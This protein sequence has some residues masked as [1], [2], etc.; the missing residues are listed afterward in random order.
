MVY[1]YR[2]NLERRIFDEFKSMRSRVAEQ[3]LYIVLLIICVVVFIAASHR[4]V[5]S[6]GRLLKNT[7][8]ILATS[9]STYANSVLY[10]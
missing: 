6:F 8:S 5:M 9:E 1:V 10:M 4:V 3:N 2:G 7:F